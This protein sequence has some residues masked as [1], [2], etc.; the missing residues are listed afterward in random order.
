M[1]SGHKMFGPTGVELME[2]EHLEHMSPFLYGGD[3]IRE[4]RYETST[5]NDV[6]EI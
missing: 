1:L 3:M 4:V 5:W 2:K 6:F